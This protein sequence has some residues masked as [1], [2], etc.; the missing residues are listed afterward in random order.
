MDVSE[1]SLPMYN[2]SRPVYTLESIQTNLHRREKLKSSRS[3]KLLQYFRCST[4]KALSFIPILEWL[5]KYPVKEYILGDI[6]SGLS[7][8]MMQLPQSLAYALLAAVPPVFGLYSSFFPVL[9]Y[10]IFGTSRHVS[11]GTFAVISLMVGGVAVKLAPDKMFHDSS[12][13]TTNSSVSHEARDAMRIQVAAAT[14]FLS[15]IIQFCLGLLH[16]GFVVVY[17]AEPLIRGFTTAAA[18]HVFVSQLKYL[19][20][21]KTKRFGGPLSAIYTFIAVCFNIKDTN[22]TT[23]IV[24]AICIV[25]L[26][27]VKKLNDRFKAKLPAPIPV[28]LIVVIISTGVSAGMNLNEN[29]KVDVVGYIPTGLRAPVLPDF[30]LL[31]EIFADSIAIA[32]V[33]FSMTI[34]MAKIFSLRHGY[35]VNANQELIALGI[36]NSIGS[37][38]QTFPVTTSMSRSLVQESTGGKTEIA[39]G[40]SALV[41]LLVI[42]A[43]GFLFEPLPQTALAAIVMVNLKGILKQFQDIPFLWRISKCELALWL[44]AFVASFLLGLDYG[45]MVSVVFAMITVVYRTQSPKYR[46]LGQIPNTDIYLDVE[47]YEEVQEIPGIKIF[48]S[49]APLYFANTDMYVSALHK[50][51]EIDP[52]AI[53]L[54]KKKLERKMKEAQLAEGR[55]KK[56]NLKL[57]KSAKGAAKHEVVSEDVP[58]EEIQ[59]GVS[60]VP[61]TMEHDEELAVFIK[62]ATDTHSLILDFNP[63]NF[64]DS[65]GA[66]VLKA[67]I[68]TYGEIG[69]NVFMAGCSESVVE[70]LNRLDFFEK[71]V[72]RDLLFHSVHDA[73]LHCQN[74]AS[75]GDGSFTE[76]SDS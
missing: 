8:G 45:L 43:L 24:G 36:C 47:A 55:K 22:V 64:V 56:T 32:I 49:N 28:E 68:K 4:K 1:V 16:F 75:F 65:V 60:S 71:S 7:T 73:V 17:L 41:V 51:T 10:M 63:V 15:G 29:Y 42:V 46:I 35:S 14:A 26:L 76:R 25:I 50:K 39:G 6:I 66:K 9:L 40:I 31:N 33:G 67:I 44:V 72:T 5:P 57:I 52:V 18:V 38:F 23:V 37:F 21:I 48:Q 54:A 61:E 30:S 34:S 27:V 53:S 12:V 13:N 58:N 74:L 70:D 59:N 69:I 19:L 62:S 2:I 20:G 3:A 11:I